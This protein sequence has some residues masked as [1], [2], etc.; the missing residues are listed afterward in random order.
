LNIPDITVGLETGL[1]EAINTAPLVVAGYMWFASL[2]HMIDIPWA[3]LSGA[4]LV[5][6]KTWERIPENLR[7]VLKEI[8]EETGEAVQKSLLTWE[9]D[10][11]EAMTDQGLVVI[12]PSPEDMAEWQELF[13]WS[14][15]QLKGDVIP[16]AWFL[17]A[18]RIGKQ[19]KVR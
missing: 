8:A 13:E 9:Q 16:E 18:V 7:P 19:G 1:V 6:L 3:P 14:W 5:D 12:T 4:T 10:V 17:E 15:D 11:I 2:K